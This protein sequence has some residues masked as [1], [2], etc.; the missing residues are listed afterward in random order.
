MGDGIYISDNFDR[1]NLSN[2]SVLLPSKAIDRAE[3][4]FNFLSRDAETSSVPRWCT[5]RGSANE[6]YGEEEEEEDDDEEELEMRAAMGT[7]H[8]GAPHRNERERRRRR[9]VG[10]VFKVHRADDGRG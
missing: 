9:K 4:I 6:V 3:S 8:I 2:V 5:S 7:L 1:L 10:R